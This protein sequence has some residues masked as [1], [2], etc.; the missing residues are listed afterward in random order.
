MVSRLA[1]MSAAEERF[2]QREASFFSSFAKNSQRPIDEL[3][4]S[5]DLDG[6]RERATQQKDTLDALAAARLLSSV[7]VRASFYEPRRLLAQGDTLAAL[8]LYGLAQSIHPEDAQL[9][10]E[11]QR[12]FLEFARSKSAAREMGCDAAAKSAVLH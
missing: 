3:R 1:S 10:A 2:H 7:F 9:C 8:R 12:L 6:L 11:R 5:L 4:E